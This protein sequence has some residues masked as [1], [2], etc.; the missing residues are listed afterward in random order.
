MGSNA[1]PLPDLDALTP[2]YSLGPTIG[3]A[4][5]QPKSG[6]ALHPIDPTESSTIRQSKNLIAEPDASSSFSVA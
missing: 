1:P 6:R 3:R 5:T 4:R 2:D